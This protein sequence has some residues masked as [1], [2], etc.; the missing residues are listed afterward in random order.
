MEQAVGRDLKALSET[1]LLET[2]GA[3]RGRIYRR[4]PAL[5][6]PYLRHYEPRENIDPFERNPERAVV[7]SKTLMNQ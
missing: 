1:G 3:T 2:D 6:A 7:L 5:H 4:S